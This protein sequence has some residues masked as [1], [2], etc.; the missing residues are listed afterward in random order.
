MPGNEINLVLDLVPVSARQAHL[1]G[2][3]L[4]ATRLLSFVSLAGDDSALA[5]ARAPTQSRKRC[6][7]A[8]DGARASV[9]TETRANAAASARSAT[10]QTSIRAGRAGTAESALERLHRMVAQARARKTQERKADDR[11]EDKGINDIRSR[12]RC[13]FTA[14]GQAAWQRVGGSS[15]ACHPGRFVV[16]GR[17]DA[18]VP[19]AS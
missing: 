19:S 15:R 13:N 14:R 17:K 16:W 5:R 2:S 3:Q 6:S 1:T 4:V 8:S 18:L 11:Q 7:A 9:C 10:G 12:S